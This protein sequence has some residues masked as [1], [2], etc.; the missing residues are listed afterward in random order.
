MNL[1]QKAIEDYTYPNHTCV[2]RICSINPVESIYVGIDPG[3]TNAGLAVMVLDR[4]FLFQMK[5]KPQKSIMQRLNILQVSIATALE[6]VDVDMK[7]RQSYGITEGSSYGSTYG[8]SSLG[9]ARAA[10]ALAVR[11]NVKCVMEILPPQSIRKLA[12]GSA[13]ITGYTD[14]PDLPRDSVAALGCAIAA[15]YHFLE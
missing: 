14:H 7:R 10:L 11:A 2:L 4:L 13:K 6:L 12:Y 9:E 3:Y 5:Y 15:Q 8:Q 1:E